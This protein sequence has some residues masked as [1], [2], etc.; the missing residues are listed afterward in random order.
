MTI[1]VV[2]LHLSWKMSRCFLNYTKPLHS[3]SLKTRPFTTNCNT[4]NC[5]IRDTDNFVLE[6]KRSQGCG[7]SIPIKLDLVTIVLYLQS[8]ATN[9]AY[10]QRTDLQTTCT[11]VLTVLYNSVLCQLISSV[12]RILWCI[13][14]SHKVELRWPYSTVNV[15]LVLT[16]K[17]ERKFGAESRNIMFPKSVNGRSCSGWIKSLI[18]VKK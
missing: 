14:A 15:K 17:G 16:N 13:L 3:K 4:G 8:T 7:P 1:F 6:L 2:Y 10:S 18:I 5:I 11:S 12:T 9:Y